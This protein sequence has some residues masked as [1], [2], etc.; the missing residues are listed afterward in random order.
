MLQLQRALAAPTD[1]VTIV[2]RLQFAMALLS[3]PMISTL[4]VVYVAGGHTA[5]ALWCFGYVAAT[6]VLV[7]LV[8]IT[9]NFSI[10]R[11]P[12]TAVVG[13]L[14]LGL[15]IWLGGFANS[16]GALMWTL[17]VPIAA[18]MFGFPRVWLWFAYAALA[19]VIGYFAYDPTR[20]ELTP[21]ELNFHFAFN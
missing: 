3:M 15:H 4:G 13:A 6:L 9:G 20:A 7:A 18:T 17:I 1:E 11:L 14:P 5:A 2:R 16:G 19:V 8:C 21:R 12:H 10:L